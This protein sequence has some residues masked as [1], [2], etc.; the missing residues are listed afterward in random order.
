LAPHPHQSGKTDAYRRVRGGRPELK[1]VLFMAAMVAAKS[2]PT[3]RALYERLLQ[4]GKKKLV[5]LTAVMRKL[6]VLC[7]ALLRPNATGLAANLARWVSGPPERPVSV[8]CR[9][10]TFPPRHRAHACQLAELS[11]LMTS[12]GGVVIA[13][14]AA[15]SRRPGAR[16]W[17]DHRRWCG[18]RGRGLRA[19]RT[20]RSWISSGI[21]R[22]GCARCC[23]GQR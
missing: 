21:R 5:A 6:V 2:N 8:R 11:E 16:I 20:A 3:Q 7:N 12:R 23:R 13:N 9:R 14:A 15:Q 1:R 10:P 22:C 18:R 17:C 19:R 4:K